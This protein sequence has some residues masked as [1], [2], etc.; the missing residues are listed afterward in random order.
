MKSVSIIPNKDKMNIPIYHKERENKDHTTMLKEFCTLMGLD[1]TSYRTVQECILSYGGLIITTDNNE[2]ALTWLPEDLSD[3]QIKK[4]FDLEEFY[5]LFQDLEFFD[6]YG[7]GL[8]KHSNE[9]NKGKEVLEEFYKAL[10]QYQKEKS[11]HRNRIK[12]AS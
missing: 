12:E 8:G 10:K 7:N 6:F 1:Y 9:P 5:R 3:E 4:L 11:M 2:Y